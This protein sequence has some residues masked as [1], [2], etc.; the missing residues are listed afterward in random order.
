[1]SNRGYSEYGMGIESSSHI[2]VLVLYYRENAVSLK[3]FQ[4]LQKEESKSGI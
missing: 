3:E 2:F 4:V 1:M